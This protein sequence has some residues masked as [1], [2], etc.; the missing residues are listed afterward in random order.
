MLR[1]IIFFG[2]IFLFVLMI[3]FID[4]TDI[5]GVCWGMNPIEI[6]KAETACHIPYYVHNFDYFSSTNYFDGKER[7]GYL[8]KYF[9]YNILVT[10]SFES[11]HLVS[12]VY[13][14]TNVFHHDE[15]MGHFLNIKELMVKEYGE[16]ESTLAGEIVHWRTLNSEI[17][18]LYVDTFNRSTIMVKFAPPSPESLSEKFYKASADYS[19]NQ[20]K[21][22]MD[23]AEE[24]NSVL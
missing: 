4:L 7:L 2:M 23:D 1:N 17:T 8:D 14:V 15:V 16:P 22:Y 18:L 24:T 13:Q 12:L 3:R 19:S 9:N 11:N 20:A 10:Y 6:R 5:R 21:I